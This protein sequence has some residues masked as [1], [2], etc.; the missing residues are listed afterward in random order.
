MEVVE[1]A[2]ADE[3]TR[4]HCAGSCLCGA[5]GLIARYAYCTRNV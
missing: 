3:K 2:R 1:T 4:G 5:T